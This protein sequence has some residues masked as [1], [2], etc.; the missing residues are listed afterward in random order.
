VL[1]YEKYFKSV[2]YC[3]RSPLLC[4]QIFK[5]D[6]QVVRDSTADSD[7]GYIQKH[8]QLRQFARHN[9]RTILS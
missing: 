1:K 2:E 7:F 9:A 4:P 8:R 6:L 5:K 3:L